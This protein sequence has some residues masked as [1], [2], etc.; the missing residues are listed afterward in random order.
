MSN[1][2][3]KPQRQPRAFSVPDDD[4]EQPET[5]KA[6]SKSSKP[7]GAKLRKASVPPISALNYDQTDED[8]FAAEERGELELV[9]PPPKNRLKRGGLRLGALAFAASSFLITASIGLWLQDLVTQLLAENTWLGWLAIAA[10]AVLALAI[11][12]FVIR[13][14]GSIWKLRSTADL[15]TK[16]EVALANNNSNDINKLI[17]QLESHFQDQP[18]T[19]HGR[20]ILAENSN[21][22]MDAQDRYALAERELMTG[23]DAEAQ[24][25]VANSA[26]RVSVVTAVSP[27]ALID[28]GYVLYENIRLIRVLCELYGGRSGIIGTMSLARRVV[29]HL[30]ITGTIAVGEGVIQQ[31]LGHGLAAKLSARLGEGVVNGV[32]TARIGLAAIDVCRPAPFHALEKPKLSNFISMLTKLGGDKKTAANNRD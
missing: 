17:R 19:A 3:Q 23:L 24:K 16:I 28:V 5:K 11:A 32:M 9:A 4:K 15:R 26:K 29:A 13:E 31:L 7:K 25:I 6:S 30:A 14:I 2:Q 12:V 21:E 8:Y 10:T 27:R 22:V 18:M 20:A 1:G